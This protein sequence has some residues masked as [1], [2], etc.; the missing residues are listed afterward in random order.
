[1]TTE[2][3]RENLRDSQKSKLTKHGIREL[4]SA[5]NRYVLCTCSMNEEL[6]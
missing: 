3:P 4:Y 2:K 1:M 6:G 5:S